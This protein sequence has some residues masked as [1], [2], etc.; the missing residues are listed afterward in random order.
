MHAFA[1]PY[2]WRKTG[3]GVIS[4]L[5]VLLLLSSAWT[6]DARADDAPIHR[7]ARLSFLQGDVTVDHLDN[8]AGDPAQINMPLAEGARLTT[9]ED[10]QAEVEFEDGSVVRLTPNS[11]LGLTALSIDPAENFHTQMTVLHGLVYAEL[12][13]S[14]KYFY[15]VDAGGALVSPVANARI[16]INLDQP[17]ATISVFN[18][19]VQIEHASTPQA[20]GYKKD[21]GAGESLTGD[22]SDSSQYS[23]SQSVE[24]DSWDEWNRGRDQARAD[25]ALNRTAARDGFAGGQGYGWS[26]LDANGSWYDVPGQ[27][28]VWQPTIAQDAGDFDPYGYGSWVAYPGAGYVWASGYAWGWTPF[29]CGHWSYWNGF[30]WGWSPGVG[31]RRAGFNFGTGSSGVFAV[32]IVHPPLNYHAPT[33]PGHELGMLHPIPVGRAPREP[34]TWSHPSHE[35]RIIAGV[36][37]QPM[38]PIANAGPSKDRTTLGAA[39]SRFPVDHVGRQPVSGATPSTPAATIRSDSRPT[40]FRPPP[41]P[42]AV[43]GTEQPTGQ[44][45]TSPPPQNSAYPAQQRSAYPAP[46][47]GEHP[48]SRAYQPAYTPRQSTPASPPP[49]SR[50]MPP[51]V[52]H[53]TPNAPAA[54]S[55]K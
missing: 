10:G 14:S 30:G 38:R 47:Q 19:T 51:P 53:T 9:G 54:A 48:G 42:I 40:T 52:P 28:Q 36:P 41:P 55:P 16:R 22:V 13:A 8:T 29:H 35:P 33:R 43:N 20:D 4:G 23:V 17:P 44:M 7:A 5:A 2:R 15:V 32:N 34:D 3:S 46:I 11:S 1:W 39:P 50:P 12:R 6:V 27:G 49:A 18:G 25:A 37:A 26:D 21:V 24:Q 45:R 31:C